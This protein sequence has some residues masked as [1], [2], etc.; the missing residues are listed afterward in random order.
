MLAG[1][2][3]TPVLAGAIVYHAR[4]VCE[5]VDHLWRI[6][7]EVSIPVDGLTDHRQQGHKRD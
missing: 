3:D 7:G 2:D 5:T 4:V 1:D 6:L